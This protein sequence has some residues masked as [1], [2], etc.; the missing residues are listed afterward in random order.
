[1]SETIV[2]FCETNHWDRDE[3]ARV[4]VVQ[5]S[6]L[7]DQGINTYTAGHIETLIMY[8]W[9]RNIN[10]YMTTVYVKRLKNTLNWPIL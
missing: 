2:E 8:N 7:P 3:A 9:V 6:L 4:G 10:M 5:L 1:M